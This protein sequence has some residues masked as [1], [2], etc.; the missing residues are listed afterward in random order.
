[1]GRRG[2][3]HQEGSGRAEGLQLMAWRSPRA[4][5]SGRHVGSVAIPTQGHSA[6]HNALFYYAHKGDFL[7]PYFQVWFGSGFLPA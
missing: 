1:M 3:R 7:E 4:W 6:H 2:R 5:W